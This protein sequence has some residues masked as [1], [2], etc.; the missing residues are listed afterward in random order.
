M[1][2]LRHASDMRVE[3]YNAAS[4]SKVSDVF[5]GSREAGDHYFDFNTEELQSGKYYCKLTTSNH[6]ASRYFEV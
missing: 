2:T 4:N 1:I 5:E 3:L 6:E